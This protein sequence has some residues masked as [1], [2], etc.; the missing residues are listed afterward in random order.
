MPPYWKRPYTYN[1]YRRRRRWRLPRRRTRKAFRRRQYWR[2]R[3]RRYRKVKK[4][5]FSKKKLKITIQQFQ[6]KSIRRCKIIGTKC[7]LQGSPLRC[8]FNYDQYANSI[9]P[10]NKPGGGGWSIMIFSLESLF[11]DYEKLLNIW[12]ASN[13]SLPLV[14]YTGCTFKFYQC[15]N[16]DYI[17]VYD[18]CWPMVDTPYTHADASPAGMFLKKHKITIPSRQTQKNKKPYKKVK[19]KPPTQ[20]Q[21]QWYFQK[22]ICKIPLVMLTTT[23]VSL[24]HPFCSPKAQS[25]NITLKMLNTILFQVPNFQNY[26]KTS[27]Y[28]PKSGIFEH[29]DIPFKAYLYAIHHQTDTAPQSIELKK[30]NLNNYTI[31][32][33]AN[34]KINQPGTN[35]NSSSYEN[36][37]KHWGNPFYHDYLDE[38][39]TSIYFSNMSPT[40]LY[41]LKS[42]EV[43]RPWH[44]TLTSPILYTYRYNPET[45]K[46]D[47]NRVYL[48]NNSTFTTWNAPDNQNLI[49]E[50]YPLPILLWGWPDWIKKAKYTINPDEN[51]ILVIETKQFKGNPQQKYVLLD[52]DFIDGIEQYPINPEHPSP[53][54]S[55]SNEHWYPKL[56]FQLQSIEKL[57]MSGHGCPRMPANTYMQIYCKYKFYFKWG[58]CPKTLEKA[59]DPCQQPKWTTTNTIPGRLEIS[60]PNTTPQTEIYDWD[61]EGDYITEDCIERI[62][63]YTPTNQSTLSISDSKNQPKAKKRK[64]ETQE[65]PLQKK[66]KLLLQLQQLQY[67]RQQLQLLLQQ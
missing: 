39:V 4:R 57:C 43:S 61:W 55:W 48:V 5:R 24:T 14:R 1:F 7:L 38:Q 26:P 52:D 3:H 44:L 22:D 2:R 54:N 19:I 6:P 65:T 51:Q 17:V 36:N 29:E 33:L 35:I 58:G 30:S 62:K 50:G 53:P 46:G 63:A 21:T 37:E 32:V 59:Y 42:T 15:E 11:D 31:Y 49:F 13:A 20:M 66:K 8:S 27:G 16:L 67:Q 64:S 28:S 9:T 41:Q 45:D 40:D 47:T 34:T 25:N 23:G 12:T 18:R 10:V 60:N 56:E